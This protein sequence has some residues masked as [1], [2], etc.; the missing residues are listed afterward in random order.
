MDSYSIAAIDSEGGVLRYRDISDLTA[1]LQEQIPE[2]ALCFLLVENNVGGIAWVMSM[3]AA[4]K[5]V[6]L[7]L[8]VK[9]DETLLNQLRDTY[10]PTYICAPA[11]FSCAT[12][13]AK[14][15]AWGYTL[16]ETENPLCEL[17][18]ELSHLLPTSGSTG[19]PKLVRHMY[20]NIEA[21]GL[22]ISTFFELKAADRPLMVL[23]L[24]YTMGLSMVFSHLGVGATVLV[25]GGNMT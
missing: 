4:R 20:G 9:T 7:V 19:S 16:Y 15:K 21:A 11:A 12:G 5:L 10:R 24:Y 22:N 25:A 1:R 14:E 18:P 17:H 23:P 8:N 2:R 13:T 3:L 6:P